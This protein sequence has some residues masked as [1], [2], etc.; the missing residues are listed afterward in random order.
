MLE[1]IA[2]VVIGSWFFALANGSFIKRLLW[3]IG[4][5]I[6]YAVLSF[7]LG[8]VLGIVISL[9]FGQQVLVEFQVPLSLS[10]MAMSFGILY[11]IREA[12]FKRQPTGVKATSIYD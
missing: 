5:I 8:F 10:I 1:I 12:I 2:I 4:G 6:G 9:T 7:I 11:L 3:A